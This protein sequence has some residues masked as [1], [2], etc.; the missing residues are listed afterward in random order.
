MAVAVAYDAGWALGAGGLV[1]R[2]H[3]L[4]R[5]LLRLGVLL[6][7]TRVSGSPPSTTDAASALYPITSSR[8]RLPGAFAEASAEYEEVG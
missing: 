7:S 4:H 5:P 2:L 1:R 6:H 3:R 8:L